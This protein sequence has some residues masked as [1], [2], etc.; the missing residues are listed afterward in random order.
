M[1]MRM[2]EEAQLRETVER[3]GVAVVEFGA[4]WCPP[5]RTLEPMLDELAAEYGESAAF[6]KIDCDAA[7]EL[8]TA[9]GIMGMPTVIVFKDG[10]PVDKL[11]GLRPK[12]VYRNVIDRLMPGAV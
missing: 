9:Y 4:V 3:S 2:I 8:T 11:V 12:A 1:G 7:A 5:C 10:Q 6:V